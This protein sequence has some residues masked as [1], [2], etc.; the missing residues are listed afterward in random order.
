MAN[1]KVD[2]HK[3]AVAERSAQPVYEDARLPLAAE[4][5]GDGLAIGYELEAADL[6]V[7]DA[8]SHSA[9]TISTSAT[10]HTHSGAEAK[11]RS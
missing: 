1:Q 7:V 10:E 9:A 8:G 6:A 11:R 4:S 5:A 2:E 3:C